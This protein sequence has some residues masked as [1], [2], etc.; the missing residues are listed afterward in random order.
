MTRVLPRAVEALREARRALLTPAGVAG[1][2]VEAA[3]VGLHFA[4]YPWGLLEDRL[5]EASHLGVSHLSPVQRGLIVGDV[6]AAGTPIILIHGVIDNRS[7]FT[8]LRRALRGRGFGRTYALNYS[9]FTDDITDVAARLGTLIDEVCDQTGYER[10]HIIGHSMG[11]LVARY[12]VQRLGGDRHVHTL[13]TLGTPHDGTLPA[14]YVPWPVIRQMRKDSPLFDDL[15]RP[16]PG[17]RTRFV[18]IWSDLDQLV[19]PQRNARIQH[20]DLR[21]RNVL[22]RGIGHMSLP[23]DRRVVNEISQVLAQLDHDGTQLESS[24]TSIDSTTG[25]AAAGAPRA[26]RRGRSAAAGA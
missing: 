26:S 8:L 22:I 17:C 11:G 15:R 4:L 2:A 21:A 6:E 10:V 16:A 14:K 19:L 24:V 5:D 3:W 13:C 9:P 23:V 18:A 1:V 12:Y 20:P 7:I 25:R